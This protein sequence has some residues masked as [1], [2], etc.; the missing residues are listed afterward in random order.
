L[1]S[2]RRE[3]ASSVDGFFGALSAS[4]SHSRRR[5]G[6]AVLEGRSSLSRAAASAAVRAA[7]GAGAPLAILGAVL[8]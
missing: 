8:G 7:E 5:F 3:R 1:I 2:S 4:S 6:G